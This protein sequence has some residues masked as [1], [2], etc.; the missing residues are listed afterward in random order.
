MDRRTRK[1]YTAIFSAYIELKNENPEDEPLIKEICAKADINKTTFYRYFSDIESLSHSLIKYFINKLL[2]EDL[3]IESIFSEPE[4]Y[5]RQMLLRLKENQEVMG[6]IHGNNMF[7]YEAERIIKNKLKET[8]GHKYDEVLYTFLAG[9]A[10][11]FFLSAD[12]YEENDIKK[13]C[14]IIK[15]AIAAMQ[16]A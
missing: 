8:L 3:N 11:H 10:S 16:N 7:I 9:G 5:F 12:Y 15:S 13:M 2:I 14:K 1:T 4:I 6:L